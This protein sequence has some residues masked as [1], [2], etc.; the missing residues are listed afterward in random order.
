MPKNIINPVFILGVPRSGTTLLRAL[1]DSHSQILGAPETGWITGGYGNF[2]LRQ[3]VESLANDPTGA[4]KNLEG[5]EEEVIF[6]STKQ[7]LTSIFSSYLSS[8]GKK[9]LVLKTPDDIRYLDFIDRLFPSANYIHIYRDGRD[10]ACSTYR[11]KDQFFGDE[12]LQEFGELTTINALRRWVDWET[13]VRNYLVNKKK[14]YSRCS[15]EDLVIKPEVILSG[16]CKFLKVPFEEEMLA[17][18]N[19]DHTFPEWEAGSADVSRKAKIDTTSVNVWQKELLASQWNQADDVAGKLLE[20]L[21]YQTCEVKAKDNRTYI[22]NELEEKDITGQK[23]AKE[24]ESTRRQLVELKEANQKVNEESENL[25]GLKLA[26]SNLQELLKGHEDKIESQDNLVGGVVTELAVLKATIKAHDTEVI[27]KEKAVIGL[28]SELSELNKALKIRDDEIKIQD[29]TIARV[30]SELSQSNDAIKSLNSEIEGRDKSIT[31][32]E[33]E[34]AEVNATLE[35]RDT[36]ISKRDKT[37]KGLESEL[38]GLKQAGEKQENDI[39]LLNSRLTSMQEDID[40]EVNAAEQLK[41]LQNEEREN[42][43]AVRTRLEAEITQKGKSIDQLGR[44]LSA[45]NFT[46]KELDEEKHIA[47]QRVYESPTFRVGKIITSPARAAKRMI[48]FSRPA[49]KAM[50]LNEGPIQE[51]N[52]IDLGQ[53]LSG[54]YGNHRSGW[55]YAVASLAPLHNPGSV[56]LDT[57]IEKTFVWSPDGIKPHKKPWVGFIHVPPNVP[58]WFQYGQSNQAIFATRAWKDSLPYCQGLFTLSQYHKKALEKQFDFPIESFIHP[59]EIP[60]IIWDWN[61]F[62][63][64]PDKKIIQLGWWL[65]KLHAIYQLPPSK[66]RKIFLKVTEQQ[67]MKDLIEKERKILIKSGELKESMFETTDVVSYLPDEEYDMYLSENIGFLNLYDSSANN[68]II[69]CIARGTPLLVN[70]L[71]PVIDYLGVDYPFYYSSLDEA[72]LKASDLDLVK[73]THE[74]LLELP[75]RQKFT[76]DYFRQ[77]LAESELLSSL[78]N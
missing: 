14:K 9:L 5:V 66:Y 67:Y 20:S 23:L 45:L 73:R 70:P 31:L 7:F 61:R 62:D 75:I 50:A 27:K 58:K 13:K 37:I 51:S 55:A 47:I 25:G 17:Y 29:K 72:V 44:Q 40:N 68:A 71:E 42:W 3:L 41:T 4:V 43:F 30:E 28:N 22:L 15:Y 65:R 77:S 34:L 46:V 76:A 1:L 8:S 74:Y 56:Y 63:K 6:E 39:S 60:E 11:Q 10:V 36:M 18:Q 32:I 21:G 59:T 35:A 57:F 54:F 49:K 38:L 52:G 26:L 24:L 2:S 78:G 48:G 19:F 12:V 53:Q 33:A 69:E 64:N 16:I